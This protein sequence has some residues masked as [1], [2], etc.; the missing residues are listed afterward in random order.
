MLQALAADRQTLQ[1]VLGAMGLTKPEQTTVEGSAGPA[2]DLLL[3]CGNGDAG[4]TR[5]A[6]ALETR[7][8]LVVTAVT[9]LLQRR[10]LAGPRPL[11]VTDQ[12]GIREAAVC[13]LSSGALEA[14]MDRAVGVRQGRM[15]G[16]GGKRAL[17][18]AENV[19]LRGLTLKLRGLTLQSGGL[20]TQLPLK[21]GLLPK[22]DRQVERRPVRGAR[23]GVVLSSEEGPDLGGLVGGLFG[24][25]I[26]I[27]FG[28]L[29]GII[30]IGGL[31]NTIEPATEPGGELLGL[32][33]VPQAGWGEGS[34][35]TSALVFGQKLHGA[36]RT[37]S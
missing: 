5:R 1:N 13:G 27:L 2:E 25:L 8:V 16:M 23:R 33:L 32:C 24:I 14:L 34:S 12:A 26:G 3:N 6:G 31:A 20:L 11:R 36:R 17:V 15:G 18:L 35:I 21:Q 30:G 4:G 10:A 19:K 28:I 9:V 22:H 37:F 7:L 29:I